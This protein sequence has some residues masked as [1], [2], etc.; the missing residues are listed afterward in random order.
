M[1]ALSSVCQKN[2]MHPCAAC[3]T[4][5]LFEWPLRNSNS[6]RHVHMQ[7]PHDAR[8]ICVWSVVISCA[9]CASSRQ[10]AMAEVATPTTASPLLSEL[11]ERFYTNAKRRTDTQTHAHTTH[12]TAHTNTNHTPTHT[13]HTPSTQ[14]HEPQ[15]HAASYT[16]T[17]AHP[18]ALTMHAVAASRTTTSAHMLRGMRIDVRAA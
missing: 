16:H 2:S 8:C 12:H 5:A 1:H 6:K 13:N 11:A 3:C 7:Q 4:R 14:A 17:H 18:N 15:K 9:S 10:S